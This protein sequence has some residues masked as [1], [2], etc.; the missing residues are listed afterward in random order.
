MSRLLHQLDDALETPILHIP[1]RV[2]AKAMQETL[3][4]RVW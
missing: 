2:N 3:A 1:V 4:D